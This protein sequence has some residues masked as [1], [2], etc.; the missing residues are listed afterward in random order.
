M[1]KYKLWLYRG[2]L[3]VSRSKGSFLLIFVSIPMCAMG[4]YVHCLEL[5]TKVAPTQGPQSQRS[6]YLQ[7]GRD[8]EEAHVYWP[9]PRC[10][11][12]AWSQM[13]RFRK[14]LWVKVSNC[15]RYLEIMPLYIQ[16]VFLC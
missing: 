2:H 1:G 11:V 4:L 15:K 5:N 14:T 8:G 12:I 10:L 9:S 13:H 16:I 7:E 6:M 3:E